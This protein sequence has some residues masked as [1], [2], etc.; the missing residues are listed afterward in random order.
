MAPTGQVVPQ[1]WSTRTLR[2]RPRSTGCYV[3]ALCLGLITVVAFLT[4]GVAG[5]MISAGFTTVLVALGEFFRR[6]EVAREILVPKVPKDPPVLW[7]RL[8][9]G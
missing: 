9:D 5:A 1:R 6:T 8:N 3:G 2:L 4:I 7:S